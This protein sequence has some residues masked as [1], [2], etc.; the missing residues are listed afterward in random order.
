MQRC[1]RRPPAPFPTST[2]Q[3]RCPRSIDK[4]SY[5][6]R[7]GQPRRG[8][9][10]RLSTLLTALARRVGGAAELP[11]LSKS[12]GSRSRRNRHLPLGS[13]AFPA[14]LKGGAR[15][16]DPAVQVTVSGRAVFPPMASGE[17][18]RRTEDTGPPRRAA[19]AA[20]SPR[21]QAR[22]PWRVSTLGPD[23]LRPPP[24]TRL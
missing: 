4:S 8:E 21:A 7:R 9:T 11:E 5:G 1:W 24:R 15:A 12:R 6:Q 2:L 13:A 18:E 22:E 14:P 20:R 23:A 19:R 3:I 16:C 17:Q 10:S